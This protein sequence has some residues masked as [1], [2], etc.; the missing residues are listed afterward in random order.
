[1]SINV[2][3]GSRFTETSVREFLTRHFRI[4]AVTPIYRNIYY[5]FEL[6]IIR[7]IDELNYLEKLRI[8]TPNILKLNRKFY[9]GRWNMI[10]LHPSWTMD[11]VVIPGVRWGALC[12]IGS[13]VLYA[14]VTYLT[15]LFFPVRGK[16]QILFLARKEGG[17]FA[18][19]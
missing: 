17:A 8:F 19:D 16:S 4:V 7:L 14:A 10:F 1:M 11:H 5:R 12:L 13:R 9:P 3:S 15:K 18:G 6:K 2:F